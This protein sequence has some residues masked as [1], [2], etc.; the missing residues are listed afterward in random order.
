MSEHIEGG[1]TPLAREEA[2]SA[3]E[4][5]AAA[6]C[7]EEEAAKRERAQ[8]NALALAF[9][10]VRA[11]SSDGKLV[12]PSRWVDLGLVPAHLEA[13]DF[14]ML[15]YEYWEEHALGDRGGSDAGSK[16]A[17][18]AECED[19]DARCEPVSAD[20]TH[21]ARTASAGSS[22][23]SVAPSREGGLFERRSTVRTATRPVG[24]PPLKR[25][26]QGA[27]AHA[28]S[29]AS[30]AEGDAAAVQDEHS[31]S[32]PSSRDD[33]CDAGYGVCSNSALDVS[34]SADS[35][36]SGESPFAGL[37]IP[38]GYAL[39]EI[40][41]EW[42]LV[43]T[44]EQAAPCEPSIQCEGIKALIGAHSYYL[45]DANLMTDTFA[46][47]A[48]LAAE[49]DPVVTFVECVRE[50]SRVYPRPMPL[51]SLKNDPFKM[52]ADEIERAWA[53]ATASGDYPDIERIVA[54]NGD[55]YFFS[56]AYLSAEYAASLAEWDA[57]ERYV[58][59]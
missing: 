32:T 43:A 6:A 54:S 33:A 20:P 26:A 27:Q 44:G 41:G 45:Y 3:Q 19:E 56:T 7:G 42:V 25:H 55:V 2:S 40:E 47:W 17:L 37:R 18:K 9:D 8:R 35:D 15:V 10:D 57:V 51:Q 14:E 50:D 1:D 4:V 22:A 48:F 13:E 49:D 12:S 39:E 31:A 21:G 58:N 46:H 29:A 5:R 36:L 34:E 11:Q 24:V 52:S 30:P 16:A 53:D 59:V 38:E 23:E 28:Q